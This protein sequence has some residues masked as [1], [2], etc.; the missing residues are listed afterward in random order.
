MLPEKV[1]GSISSNLNFFFLGKP[2]RFGELLRI[3]VKR[4]EGVIFY[5][6]VISNGPKGPVNDRSTSLP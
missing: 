2:L 4:I 1:L 5:I 3:P 6:S